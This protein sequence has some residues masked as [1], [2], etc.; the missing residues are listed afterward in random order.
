MSGIVIIGGG[1][2]G[3]RAAR[4]V[5]ELGYAG[6]VTILAAEPHFPYERPPL[7]K[8]VLQGKHE[9]DSVYLKPD[10]WY[11]EQRI[12]V[13]TGVRVSA[14][15][16]DTHE[17]STESGER[18]AYDKLVI[19][20]GSRARVL[21]IEGADLAGVHTL[22]TVDESTEL[23]DLLKSGDRRVVV[24]GSG[25]IG[26]EV[27]ASARSLGNE[28]TVVARGSVPLSAALGNTL[29]TE[30]QRLHESHGVKFV[31]NA[32]VD[33][34][35][36]DGRVKGVVVNGETIPADLVVV[37]VGAEPNTE[38]ATAAGIEVDDGI[39]TDDSF[40]TSAADVFA[41]GDVANVQHPVAGRRLRSEH[42][43]NALNQGK[44]VARALTGETVSYDEIPYFYTD[45]FELGM[46][47]SGYPHLMKDA[48]IVVRG[49]LAANEYIAFWVREGSVV[50]GMN[51]NIWDVNEAVQQLIRSKH[52]ID[53][54]R[55]ADT[56]STLEELAAE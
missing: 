6:D 47:L 33:R 17:V 8:E 15:H 36:G 4:T 52:T 24:I 16:T 41:I 22:R 9:P 14:I 30:F 38:L 39:L 44:A 1:L 40:R 34:I 23:H 18:L 28:V 13:R 10:D 12:D 48:K 54:S 25:W 11:A 32:A 31:M 53:E 35:A 42:W 29:G 55:L 5:R 19:A 45:Q 50:A 27:A 20:T 3:G 51:V 37:G 7:S 46:E 43:S 26:M 2:A 49:D 56:N 21:D